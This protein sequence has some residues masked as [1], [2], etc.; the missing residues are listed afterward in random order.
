LLQ[1]LYL[2]PQ[3]RQPLLDL[4]TAG[5]GQSKVTTAP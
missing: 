3:T 4:N 2:S 5:I 1:R